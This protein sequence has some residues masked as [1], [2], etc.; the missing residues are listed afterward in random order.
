MIFQTS[1]IKQLRQFFFLIAL[2]IG[3]IHAWFTRYMVCG[4]AIPYL[5][6]GDAYF[7]ADWSSAINLTYSPLYSWILG[8]AIYIFKPLAYW[9]STFIHFINLIIFLIAFFC[10]DFFLQQLIQYHKQKELNFSK[11]GLSIL[12]EWAW[13][14]L[15]YTLFIWSSMNLITISSVTPDMCVSAIVYLITGIMLKIQKGTTNRFTF[16][17]LGALLGLGYLAKAIML[18]LA[19]IYLALS[20]F[21]IKN[22][23]TAI[24][25]ILLTSLVFL[26]ISSPFILAISKIKGSLTFSEC[27]ILNYAWNLNES[28]Y[29]CCKTYEPIC[30]KLIHP[31]RTIFNHPKAYEYSTPIKATDP[32]WQIQTYWYDGLKPHF[33]L[34]GQLKIFMRTAYQYFDLFFHMQ[35]MLLTGFLVLVLINLKNISWLKDIYEQKILLIPAITAMVLY[36]LIHVELR[37]LGPFVVLFWLG[38]FSILKLSDSKEIKKIL[39]YSIIILSIFMLITS[40][41]SKD[42]LEN[43]NNTSAYVQWQIADELEKAGLKK[44]DKAAVALFD[45]D[46]YWARLAKMPVIAEVGELA[47]F[48]AADD[49]VKLEVFK[50]FKQAGAKVVLA[51]RIPFYT[52]KINW[53]RVKDTPFYFYVL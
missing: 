14:V 15:G 10:F 34:K 26:L 25:R 27:P 49:S 7:R 20:I 4:D 45:N 31:A 52:S 24:I 40:I 28:T 30:G 51:D 42:L 12:P 39:S 1:S 16:I 37:Y 44:G 47:D 3:L 29:E 53:R 38:L 22:L 43:F 5:D 13:L 18:P 9:E 17:L 41:I 33:T 36:F 23:R 8:L 50:A 11:S 19:F 46:F 32:I 2:I 35:G 48:W 6:I 21:L